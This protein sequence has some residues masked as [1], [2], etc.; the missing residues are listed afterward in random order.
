MQRRRL[1][2]ISLDG[3]K[4]EKEYSMQSGDNCAGTMQMVQ[5]NIDAWWAMPTE[6]KAAAASVLLPIFKFY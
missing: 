1:M 4:L 2:K 6:R 5:Y 3:A